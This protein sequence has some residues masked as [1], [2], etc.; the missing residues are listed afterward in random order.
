MT[1]LSAG[2][3]FSVTCAKSPDQY[4]PAVF[5]LNAKTVGTPSRCLVTSPLSSLQIGANPR[6]TTVFLSDDDTGMDG[7]GGMR[8]ALLEAAAAQQAPMAR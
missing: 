7:G 3:C 2:T 5:I 1:S 8:K 4:K 6:C